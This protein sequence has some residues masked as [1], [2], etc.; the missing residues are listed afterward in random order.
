MGARCLEYQQRKY[1]HTTSM[2]AKLKES[3]P[4]SSGSLGERI[5]GLVPDTGAQNGSPAKSAQ[6]TQTMDHRNGY[7]DTKEDAANAAV[8]KPDIKGTCVVCLD[9]PAELVSKECGHLAWCRTCRRE[10]V[11]FE[12]GGHI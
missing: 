12:L 6:P 9:K 3:S 4:F 8:T 11:R 1:E 5:L 7:R 2:L 10:V